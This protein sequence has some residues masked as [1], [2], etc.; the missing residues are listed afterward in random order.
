M[1]GDPKRSQVTPHRKGDF[2]VRIIRHSSSSRRI[3]LRKSWITDSSRT[4]SSFALSILERT[5]RSSVEPACGGCVC[6]SRIK[7][8]LLM[9]YT[10][11]IRVAPGAESKAIQDVT[12][13]ASHT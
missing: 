10:L 5:S 13:E 12:E 11:S 2:V 9:Q 1:N 7:Y 6:W 8:L 4:I 3:C